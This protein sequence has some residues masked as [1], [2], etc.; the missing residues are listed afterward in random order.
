[1][2]QGD[3]RRCCAEPGGCEMGGR[4]GCKTIGHKWQGWHCVESPAPV[5]A[6]APS[7][8][9]QLLQCW[10]PA[11]S[12]SARTVAGGCD[13]REA[14]QH[15]GTCKLV[16][17]GG[18][19]SPR[20]G[21]QLETR[22]CACPQQRHPPELLPASR[23]WQSISDSRRGQRHNSPCTD[24]CSPSLLEAGRRAVVSVLW[25]G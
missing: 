4:G 21:F 16:F 6:A 20:P 23:A 24:K 8:L 7:S 18:F 15:T 12:P 9:H 19:P 25:P 14:L 11:S 1:M 2:G 5:P 22:V 13:A 17:C 3:L 10:C